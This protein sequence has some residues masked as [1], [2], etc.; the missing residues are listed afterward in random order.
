MITF[1]NNKST[2]FVTL[3]CVLKDLFVKE[4]LP[5]GII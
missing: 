5:H 3:H 4:S 1:T 2:N